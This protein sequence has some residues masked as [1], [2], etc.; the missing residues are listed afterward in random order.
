MIKI[1]ADK[2]IPFLEGVLEP[3]AEVVRLD[4]RS[5][6]PREVRDADAVVVRTRTRCDARLLGGSSV[7]AVVTATIGTDHIDT[8]WCR[9]RGVAVFN[10]AGCN[11]R[12]VLQWVAAVLAHLARTRDLKPSETVLGVVGVGHV[13]SLV[14]EYASRWG[15]RTICC[16]PPRE[17]REHCGFVTAAEVFGAADI[18]TLHTPLDDTTRH[19]VNSELLASCG[20]KP[21]VINSSRGEVA[22]G[23]ALLASGVDFA[24]DVWENE[25]DI[26]RRLLERAVIATPHIAGYSL[27]GKANASAAAVEALAAFF[28]LP[29]AGWYPEGVRPSQPQPTGWE[30]MC[31]EMAERYDIDSESR[32]LKAHPELFESMRNGYDYRE[33][34]F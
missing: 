25:P 7:R 1:V 31:R 20:R 4:G 19:L 10:A 5:I 29:L 27:Q 6:G 30:Q 11:A 34:F 22:D 15:F 24:L 2:D 18:V 12:G 21:F 23:G 3:F 17:E 9:S 32:R 26:D 33:E 28:G 16:D 13:G 8:L 14:C